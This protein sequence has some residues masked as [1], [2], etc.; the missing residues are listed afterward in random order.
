MVASSLFLSNP[1]NDII[2]RR[3]GR[4]KGKLLKFV[5][6]QLQEGEGGRGHSVVV[7]GPREHMRYVGRR[8]RTLRNGRGDR[9]ERAKG[10]N[11]PDKDVDGLL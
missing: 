11:H 3:Q 7:V 9:E 6:G 2:V 4:I 5:T 1:F 10:K 8:E